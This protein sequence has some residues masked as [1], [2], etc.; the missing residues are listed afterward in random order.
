MWREPDKWALARAENFHDEVS[1]WYAVPLR[2]VLGRVHERALKLAA[3]DP[4]LLSDPRFPFSRMMTPETAPS[5]DSF[6]ERAALAVLAASAK[7][8]ERAVCPVCLLAGCGR[9]HRECSPPGSVCERCGERM[10][11]AAPSG[12]CGFCVEESRDAA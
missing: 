11:K 2:D 3:A 12:L 8:A 7:V 4:H 1:S 9:E 6:I 10:R 5:L